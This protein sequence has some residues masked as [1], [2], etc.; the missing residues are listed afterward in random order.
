MENAKVLGTGAFG[1]VIKPSLQCADKKPDDWYDGKVSKVVKDVKSANAEFSE[2]MVVHTI[3]PEHKFTLPP[4]TMCI[5]SPDNAPYIERCRMQDTF[6]EKNGQIKP[7]LPL[8]IMQEGGF[9][10]FSLASAPPRNWSPA[11]MD[12]FWVRCVPVFEGLVKLVEKGKVHQDVKIEN[13]LFNPEEGKVLLID[14]G[15]MT[16]ADDLVRSFEGRQNLNQTRLPLDFLIYT[17][18]NYADRRQ[19]YTGTKLPKTFYETVF[20]WGP[21]PERVKY[22]TDMKE[23]FRQEADTFAKGS[24]PFDEFKRKSVNTIDLYGLCTSLLTLCNYLV[25]FEGRV[26]FEPLMDLLYKCITPNVAAR[27]TADEALEEYKK[28]LSKHLPATELRPYV[29]AV[30]KKRRSTSPVGS[31][32]FEGGL[33]KRSRRRASRR[34]RGTKRA[35]K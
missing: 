11:H 27:Y 13:M 12:A 28:L 22:S 33:R 25:A 32:K 17:P 29:G 4:P 20:P 1:C 31:A 16:N 34:R 7:D 8:L 3:D 15:L 35:A 24:T 18:E 9:D 2:A 6:F 19:R 26:P 30:A 21:S 10:L 5:S 14:F 23:W